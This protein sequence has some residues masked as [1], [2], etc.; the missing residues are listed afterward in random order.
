MSGLTALLI[1]YA[2]DADDVTDFPTLC[3]ALA[4]RVD[5]LLPRHGS[6]SGTTDAN[7]YVSVTHA[8]GFTPSQVFVQATRNTPLTDAL[9]AIQ[10]DAITSTTF[11]IRFA[12]FTLQAGSNYYTTHGSVSAAF[13]CNWIAFK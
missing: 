9:L 6:S 8:L 11:R 5:E 3:A 4:E 13:S 2:D 1:P 10:V 12:K 7:G